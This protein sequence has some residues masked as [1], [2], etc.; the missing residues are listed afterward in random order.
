MPL[1]PVQGHLPRAGVLPGGRPVGGFVRVAGIPLRHLPGIVDGGAQDADLPLVERDGESG[2][3]AE[4]HVREFGVRGGRVGFDELDTEE[5][6]DVLVEQIEIQ[7]EKIRERVFVPELVL[8]GSLRLDI[9]VAVDHAIIPGAV[10]QGG[11]L[12]EVGVV[13]NVAQGGSW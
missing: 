5:V 1:I 13:K 10:L 7:T 11:Q 8:D 12:A 2:D 3:V 6:A 4:I 9:G